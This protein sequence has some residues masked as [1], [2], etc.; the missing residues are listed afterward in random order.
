MCTHLHKRSN[1]VYYFRRRVPLDLVEFFGKDE[2]NESLGT[3]DRRA[4]VAACRK[5]SVLTDAL[6][7]KAR[8]QMLE[9]AVTPGPASAK[10]MTPEQERAQWEGE[11]WA[12]E[13][14][15]TDNAFVDEIREDKAQRRAGYK[16]LIAFA[17]SLG[18][19]LPAADK[20]ALQ[21]IFARQTGEAPKV[22]D[23]PAGKVSGLDLDDLVDKWAGEKKPAAKTIQ[24]AR[25]VVTEFAKTAGVSRAGQ[26]ERS[27]VLRYKDTMLEAGQSPANINNK[28]I[29]LSTVFNHAVKNDLG[30]ASNPATGIKATDKRRAREKRLPFDLAALQAIFSSPVYIDHARPLG[31]GG[32]AAY[33]LPLIALFSGAR[34]EEIAQLHPDDVYEESYND[35]T[36]KAC[37]AWVIRFV[38]NE[39]EGQQVKT[40]SSVRR[41][42]AGL[43]SALSPTLPRF[44]GGPHG[45][46]LAGA[47][48]RE[49]R[50]LPHQISARCIPGS[51]HLRPYC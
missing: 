37:S 26:V 39:D 28:L 6:F 14:V 35:A 32:E 2:F 4:A 7:D 24:R 42:L 5:R 48:G 25:R 12:I 23:K 30:M 31:G 36:G 45:G 13:Q 50:G 16:S 46:N 9:E 20:E 1:G 49:P 40:E 27:Q 10:P 8:G 38:D 47:A 17:D 15:A 22:A 21:A 34:I 18:L 11:Q 41:S 44:G 51:R 33:W 3:K 29:M 19:G 43:G